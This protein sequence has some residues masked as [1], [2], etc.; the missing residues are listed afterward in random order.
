MPGLSTPEEAIFL[1]ILQLIISDFWP[2]K[3]VE[4]V[5]KRRFGGLLVS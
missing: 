2:P 5:F 3:I 4:N 1:V